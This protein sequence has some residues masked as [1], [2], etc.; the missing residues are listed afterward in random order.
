M[1][2]LLILHQNTKYDTANTIFILAI[3]WSIKFDSLL[4]YGL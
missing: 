3:M 2:K 4:L 1:F